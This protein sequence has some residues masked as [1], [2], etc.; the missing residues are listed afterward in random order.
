MTILERISK[1]QVIPGTPATPGT[2][3]RYEW[4]E[5]PVLSNDQVDTMNAFLG[6]GALGGLAN[7]TSPSNPSGGSAPPR[8]GGGSTS[9]GASYSYTGMSLNGVP[10]LY[11]VTVFPDGTH[12]VIRK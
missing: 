8:S 3:G 7:P 4:V 9:G 12:Q 6:F 2:P 1:T 5:D 11:I 10:G